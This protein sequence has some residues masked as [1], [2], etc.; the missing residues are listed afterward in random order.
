MGDEEATQID[1]AGC[2]LKLWEAPPKPI[3]FTTTACHAPL[4]RCTGGRPPLPQT[5]LLGRA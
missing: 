2:R 4:Q 3:P 5:K 1:F